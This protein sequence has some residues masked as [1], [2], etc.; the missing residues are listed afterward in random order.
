M[1]IDCIDQHESNFMLDLC[2]GSHTSCD[3]YYCDDMK[4]EDR[5]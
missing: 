2:N 3:I 1:Q 4:P 5:S